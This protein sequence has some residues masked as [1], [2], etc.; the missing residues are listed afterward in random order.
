MR[1]KINLAPDIPMGWPIEIAPPFTLTFFTSKPK[2]FIFAR[3]ATAKA[4][5]ISKKSISY[6][7]KPVLS[8]SF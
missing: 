8:N 2:I 3:A 6:T 7:F 5:L 4:S 1:D